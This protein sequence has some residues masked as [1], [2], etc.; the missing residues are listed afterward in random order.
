M[1]FCARVQ[2]CLDAFVWFV[3]KPRPDYV[4]VF[5]CKMENT[6]HDH[7]YLNETEFHLY[8][9]IGS[10]TNPRIIHYRYVIC[11]MTKYFISYEPMY[12]FLITHCQFDIW[13]VIG[14]DQ[15]SF[16]TYNT[17]NCGLTWWFNIFYATVL[18]RCSIVRMAVTAYTCEICLIIGIE[19]STEKSVLRWV[20]RELLTAAQTINPEIL[21]YCTALHFTALRCTAPH[22]IVM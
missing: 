21:A 5:F 6:L 20:H 18:G 15:K 16:S 9:A 1:S 17:I 2:K 3:Q 7:R 19:S 8:G 10:T 4:T 11:I 12:I 22:R 13:V 14:A